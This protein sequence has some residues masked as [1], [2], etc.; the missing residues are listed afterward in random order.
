MSQPESRIR[1]D[2]EKELLPASLSETVREVKRELEREKSGQ[3]WGWCKTNVDSLKKTERER[4]RLIENTLIPSN[5]NLA[6]SLH[7]KLSLTIYCCTSF[8]A[9]CVPQPF[10]RHS[11]DMHPRITHTPASRGCIAT[12]ATDGGERW[13]S[14]RPCRMFIIPRGWN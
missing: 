6:C 13:L 7:F 4:E 1:W 2:G 8:T 11:S 14:Q 9:T 5:T 10:T 3:L 12:E